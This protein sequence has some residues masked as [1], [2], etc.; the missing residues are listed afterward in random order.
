MN[1]N[2]IYSYCSTLG[3]LQNEKRT[4]KM[5]TP[6]ISDYSHTVQVHTYN[7]TIE[8]IKKLENITKYY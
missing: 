1:F 7:L 8:F 5:N 4:E 6:G 3:K 2:E